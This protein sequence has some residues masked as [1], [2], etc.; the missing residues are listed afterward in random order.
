MTS[1]VT[2]GTT[3]VMVAPVNRNRRELIFSNTGDN[4]I[5]LKKQRGSLFSIPS[6]TNYDYKLQ[7][8]AT[9]KIITVAAF[10][11]VVLKNHC[12]GGEE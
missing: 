4:D 5:Y 2:I 1:P 11:A 6:K 10:L 7:V 9:L 12:D 3:A 8:G